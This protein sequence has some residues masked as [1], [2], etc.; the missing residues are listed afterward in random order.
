MSCG[1]KTPEGEGQNMTDA[2][3]VERIRGWLRP[4]SMSSI[5]PLPFDKQAEE[6][7]EVEIIRDLCDDR[8]GD[9]VAGIRARCAR[10]SAEDEGILFVPAE[11]R[12]LEKLVWPLRSAKRAFSLGDSLGCIALCG[13]VCEMAVVFVYDLMS[14]D[15]D[16][17]KLPKEHQFV[18]IKRKYERLGQEKRIKSLTDMG[19]ISGS[20]AGDLETVRKLRKD[21]MHFLSKSL[22]RAEDDAS[23]A[24]ACAARIL[25]SLIGLPAS[26]NGLRIPRH[27]VRYLNNKKLIT[28]EEQ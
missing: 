10:L 1:T 13:M 25:K 7:D 9:I 8:R 19:A 5:C 6:H 21:Y 24:Y 16:V 14:L 23:L 22:S 17:Q 18:M 15:L 26:G 2:K 27:L 3:R 4:L 11:K 12:I 20:A 28:W